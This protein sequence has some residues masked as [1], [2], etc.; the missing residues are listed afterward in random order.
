MDHIDKLELTFKTIDLAGR[1]PGTDAIEFLSV[2]DLIGK[3][4]DIV[5]LCV[6]AMLLMV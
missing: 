5:R 1:V 4:V 2:E 6:F 3:V